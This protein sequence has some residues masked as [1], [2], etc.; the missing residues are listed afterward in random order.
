MLINN[1]LTHMFRYIYKIYTEI[2]CSHQQQ[3]N[4][5]KTSGL[6]VGMGEGDIR[7]PV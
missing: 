4:A 6:V 3:L 2:A 1:K 7:L 5:N